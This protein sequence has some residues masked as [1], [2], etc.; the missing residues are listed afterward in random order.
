MADE[1]EKLDAVSRR[2]KP[3]DNFFRANS[4]K[5]PIPAMAVSAAEK[6]AHLLIQHQHAFIPES[7]YRAGEGAAYRQSFRPLYPRMPAI[8]T[9]TRV[10]LLLIEDGH[11]EGS[12]EPMHSRAVAATAAATWEALTGQPHLPGILYN[13]S[14][15]EDSLGP[16]RKPLLSPPIPERFSKDLAEPSLRAWLKN[17]TYHVLSTSTSHYNIAITNGTDRAAGEKR[18]TDYFGDNFVYVQSMNNTPT[19]EMDL[20]HSAY[21]YHPDT[22]L[23]AASQSSPSALPGGPRTLH[24]ESYS[25]FGPDLLCETH[26]IS[27]RYLHRD[28]PYP[29][30]YETLQGTS[31]SAPRPQRRSSCCSA[32]SPSAPKTRKA[33]SPGTTSC[34]PC[35]RRRNPC[36]CAKTSR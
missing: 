15:Y 19:A 31:F 5:S 36:M 26:P 11:A 14:P 33:S 28:P 13:R 23:V 22:L 18:I 29:K 7:S 12:R 4:D 24:V 20:R 3:L 10:A 34:S 9:P 25:S 30:T 1:V 2:L 35:A 8:A 6:A 27:A 17:A 21:T 32:A 16:E